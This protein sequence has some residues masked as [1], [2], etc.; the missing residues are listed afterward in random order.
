MRVLYSCVVFGIV[1]CSMGRHHC[2]LGAKFG[3][4]CSHPRCAH[5]CCI[6]KTVA[7]GLQVLLINNKKVLAGINRGGTKLSI[8]MGHLQVPLSLLLFSFDKL[9]NCRAL[10][11]QCVCVHCLCTCVTIRLFFFFRLHSL[12][13]QTTVTRL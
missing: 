9:V 12:V 11:L 6:S 3:S 1:L 13:L 5:T 7:D 4:I 2:F 8:M 10:F